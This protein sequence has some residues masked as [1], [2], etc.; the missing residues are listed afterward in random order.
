MGRMI[1]TLEP[2][3]IGLYSGVFILF[4]MAKQ[5]TNLIPF[6]AKRS[7][8]CLKIIYFSPLE[9]ELKLHS[10]CFT[11]RKRG[12]QNLLHH[13]IGLQYIEDLTVLKNCLAE[14]VCFE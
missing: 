12:M 13:I 5:E 9:S 3:L 6:G 2:D 7:A 8:F 10:L 4:E 11:S 14:V 1:Y